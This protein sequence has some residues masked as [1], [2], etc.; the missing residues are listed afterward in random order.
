MSETDQG[1]AKTPAVVDA[2]RWL[3]MSRSEGMHALGITSE[4]AYERTYRDVEQVVYR[5]DNRS[6]QGGV[7]PTVVIKRS[8]EEVHDVG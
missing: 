1:D 5:R 2:A 8:G 3:G 7:R 6:S 4:A